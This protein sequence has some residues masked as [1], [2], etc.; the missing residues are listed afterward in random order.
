MMAIDFFT[1]LQPGWLNAWIPAFAM[2]II[3]FIYM[4]IFKEGA[5]RA[6]DTSW[7][8]KRDKINGFGSSILQIVLLAVSIFVP[9]K[10]GTTWFWIGTVIYAIAFIAFIFSFHDYVKAPTDKIIDKGIYK[11]SR[12][13]MYTIFIV[14]MLGV[15]IASA[16]LWILIILIP[17]SILTHFIVLGEERYCIN[18]YGEEYVEYKNKTPRYFLI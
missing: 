7:Y 6:V 17:F 1:T 4:A 13:P 10:I 18:T 12:N 3:Q 2:V 16:S 8:N 14:G 5:K 15:C 9:L 11:L